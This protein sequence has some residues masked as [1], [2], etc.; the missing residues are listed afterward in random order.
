M[1][2]VLT[3]GSTTSRRLATG[4]IVLI[5]IGVIVAL[6][7]GGVAIALCQK[8][9][10][11]NGTGSSTTGTGTTLNAADIAEELP[12]AASTGVLGDVRSRNNNK[13]NNSKN[14]NQVPPVAQRATH[15]VDQPYL[16]DSPLEVQARA[17]HAALQNPQ[18][19]LPCYEPAQQDYSPSQELLSESNAL[20]PSYQQQLKQMPA[21]QQLN[22]QQATAATNVGPNVYQGIDSHAVADL[23]SSVYDAADTFDQHVRQTAGATAGI[24]G[25]YGACDT[26]GISM[27]NQKSRMV[28]PLSMLP[29]ADPSQQANRMVQAGPSIADIACKV[30]RQADI[31]R[32]MRSGASVLSQTIPA[33]KPP[34]YTEGLNAFRPTRLP[35]RTSAGTQLFGISPLEISDVIDVTPNPFLNSSSAALAA[36]SYPVPTTL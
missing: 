30:P 2:D 9:C 17:V 8:G 11:S 6:A 23:D 22:L 15:G 29:H 25:I 36:Q 7:L 19:G 20:V 3:G 28:N 4:T 26:K 1:S 32:M 24:A 18:T 21:T 10:G 16:A 12:A 5:V 31:M 27:I 13:N 14:R 33:D 35:A 34:L